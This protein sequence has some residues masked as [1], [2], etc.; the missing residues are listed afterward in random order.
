MPEVERAALEYLVDI[1]RK[2]SAPIEREIDGR[3]YIDEKLI[4]ISPPKVT[5]LKISTLGSLVE[6]CTDKFEGFDVAKHV[7]H[8][9]SEKQVQVVTLESN[10]WKER[11]ILIDCVLTE[12]TGIEFGSFHSQEKFI[13]ALL[14]SLSSTG[15]RDELAKLAG[16][17]TAETVTTA[18]DDGVTQMVSM[19]E[20]ASLQDTKAVKG[21]VLLAPWRTFRDIEQ[22]TSTFL[23]RVKKEGDMPKFALFEADGGAWKLEAVENIAWKLSAGLTQA[24]VVS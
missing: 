15:D 4:G 20:G 10:V 12:T 11:E 8:V 7:I 2:L 19:R 13:I 16:N 17:A 9:V 18:V 24:T 14:S 22:P 5:A 23:F 21:L 3:K 1:G 6:L